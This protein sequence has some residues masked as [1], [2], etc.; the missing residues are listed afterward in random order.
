MA[1][2]YCMGEAATLRHAFGVCAVARAVQN[3]QHARKKHWQAQNAAA[4]AH[5]NEDNHGV[6]ASFVG[7]RLFCTRQPSARPEQGFCFN[8]EVIPPFLS[9]ISPVHPC[10]R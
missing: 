2:L 6:D 9:A 5:R 7:T 8:C 1:L 4:H 3:D 10:V